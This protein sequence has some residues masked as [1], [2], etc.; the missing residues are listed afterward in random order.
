MTMLFIDYT[1]L[2]LKAFEEKRSALLIA[3]F[4]Q[5][6]TTSNIK[7]ECLL[8]YTERIQKGK[9]EEEE[10]LRAFFG[11]PPAGKN[12]SYLMNKFEGDKFRPLQS[13]IKGKIKNPS[14]ENV[15]L[16]AWLIDFS[17]RPFGRAKDT[18][19]HIDISTAIQTGGTESFNDHHITGPV[20]MDV[21]EGAEVVNASN[22]TIYLHEMRSNADN[23]KEN[24]GKSLTKGS[25]YYGENRKLKIVAS[26]VFV[27]ASLMGGMYF[28]VNREPLADGGDCM[29]WFNDHYEKVPCKT[30]RV[31]NRIVLPLD[32]AILQTFKKITREDTI[33]ERSIGSIY[34]VKINNKP[35]F[36]TEAGHFPG[37]MNR[38]LKVLSRLIFNKYLGK[39]ELSGKASSGE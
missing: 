32:E 12:F 16:L 10:T 29:S 21:K 39:K 15:E 13:F 28:M 19:M 30:K 2:V 25:K 4:L 31:G 35:V 34:Y 27:I 14:P 17:P 38:P 5:H 18:S 26:I 6:P 1:N 9:E 11:V 22:Q 7:K 20:V 3:P 33:T 24:T 8:L 36:Y 23:G 37:D